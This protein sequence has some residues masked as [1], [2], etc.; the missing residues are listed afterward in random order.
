[1]SPSVLRA[2]LTAVLLTGAVVGTAAS[3]NAADLGTGGSGRPLTAALVGSN[4]VPVAGDS[5]GSGQAA[6]TI[7]PGRGELCYTLAWAQLGTV[8]AAHIHEAPAGTNG[9]V[10]I[11]LALQGTPGKASGCTTVDRQV[12]VGI[13]TDPTGYYVNFHSTEFPGGAVR[14]QLA[15]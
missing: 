8:V 12:L 10:I 11:P 6:V 9:P 13:I 1:M 5:D 15:R 7:N 2:T 3:G 4:E 14:G